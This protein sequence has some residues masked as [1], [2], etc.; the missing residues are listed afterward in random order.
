MLELLSL[1]CLPLNL[2]DALLGQ[3]QRTIPKFGSRIDM[4]IQPSLCILIQPYLLKVFFVFLFEVALHDLLFASASICQYSK[5]LI[6]LLLLLIAVEA[7]SSHS[8]EHL[9]WQVDLPST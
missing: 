7:L 5:L 6:H 3:V 1:R 2:P 8:L 4:K 9:I